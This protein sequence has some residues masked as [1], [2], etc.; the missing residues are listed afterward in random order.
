MLWFPSWIVFFFFNDT[1]TTEI[2][3]LSLHDALP[4]L[5]DPGNGTTSIIASELYNMFPID[6][7]SICNESNGNFPNH[8]PDPIVEDNLSMLKEKVI[9]LNADI[10]IAFD[11]DGDRA[12]FVDKNGEI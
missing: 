8:H 11:G 10:G 1:A 2:Y 6:V 9:E 4:I 3:T 12:G 5:I 7:I